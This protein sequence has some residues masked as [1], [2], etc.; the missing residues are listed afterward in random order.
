M[1]GSTAVRK[2]SNDSPQDVKRNVERFPEDFRFQLT[3]AELTASR[4]QS[5]ILKAKRGQNVKFLPYAFTEHG[6]IMAAAVLNSSLAV[7]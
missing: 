1:D 6:A 2:A 7:E 3:R 4:S 5:V